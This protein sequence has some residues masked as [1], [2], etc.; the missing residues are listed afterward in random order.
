MPQPTQATRHI[1]IETPLGE[2][3]LLLQ[4]FSGHEELS[5]LYE[6]DLDLL[7]ENYE[8]NFDDIIGQN[9]T[10]RMD[11]PEGGTRYWNG[12][13]SR[14][15][16]GASTSV[17]FAQYRA[18][19]VPWLWFLTRT[20]DCRIFQ[21]KTVPEIIRQIFSEHEFSDIEDRLSGEYRTW[22]YCVQYR[23][24]DYN[25]VSRLMEQEGI[26]YYFLHEQGKS[27]LVFCD[28]LG[29]HDPC[30]N[31]ES[32]DF[33]AD[34]K[35]S[36]VSERITEWTL[37]KEVRSGKFV[38][39][40]YN[41][42]KPSTFLMG[43]EENQTSN[44]RAYYEIFDYPGEFL[45]KADGD[46][47]AKMRMEELS[48]PHEVCTGQSDA[49]GI[50]TGHLFTLNR[51]TRR[52]QN[53][54]YLVTSTDYQVAAQSYETSR[55]GDQKCACFFSVI[56]SSVQYRAERI[57][58]KPII[59]GSQTAVVTGP[60]GEEIYTDDYGRVKVQFHW[61]REA[62]HDENSSCWIRVSQVHAGKSFGGI[63]IPRVGE[64]VI[65]S[66]MEGDPDQPIITGRVYNA[67]LMPPFGLPGKKVVSGMKSNS[68]PGGGGYNEITLDD[69]KGN[70]GLTIHAQ[71][72]MDT[73]VENDQTNTIHNNRTTVVDVNDTE[74]VGNKQDIS[75]GDDQTLK[76]GSNQIVSISSNRAMNI[77][78]SDT[79]DVASD[80]TL[81]VGG[82]QKIAVTGAIE[83]SSD[84]SITLSVGGST[85]KIEPASVSINSQIITVE[86]SA[87]VE[88]KG[89]LVI[90]EA[91]GINVITGATIKL[92]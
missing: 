59:Q 53:K 1:A 74:S 62:N 40:D 65:V 63:D 20:S 36:A 28:S 37:K 80:H 73:T 49:H 39:T 17:Q 68:T 42:E 84:T 61:D 71:Y 2:D 4:S 14:F 25:F 27:K 32:I 55:G 35:G 52:D 82:S 9:V 38:H 75:I 60:S 47:Y 31:Y 43:F 46:R 16:Q 77:G 30:E 33:A 45:E 23:E 90:S 12:F 6:F 29:K 64:E 7:S 13:I 92:N 76:V 88:T 24:T 11:L 78:S 67:E 57:T 44:E 58:P 66:F 3:V 86:G 85:V 51:H 87:K 19:M 81:T 79:V 69:T 83:I 41:Y 50:C 26:Y 89:A 8:V 54:E 22:K 5:R 10:I 91:T 18:T 70:E 34:T 56:P 72:N 21:E 15:V 48:Y